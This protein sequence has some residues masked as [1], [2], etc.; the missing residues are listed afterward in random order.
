MRTKWLLIA[1]PLAILALLLQSSIWVPTYASQARTNPGRLVT[2]IR[3]TIGEVKHLNPVVSSDYEANQLMSENL[4]EGLVFADEN[5]GLSPKLAER[6]ETTE[7]AYV[8]VL[9]ERR[10]RDGSRATPESLAAR[11][12][13]AWKQ[14]QLGALSNSITSVQVV[15]SERRSATE[16]V[17]IKNA[18]GKD[19]PADVE[20]SID[21]PPRVQLELSRVEPQLFEKLAEILGDAYFEPG[22]FESRFTL[23]KPE[24]LDAVRSKLPELLQVGEH[25][26]IVTFHLRPGVHWHDGVPMTAEDVKFTYQATVDPRNASPLAGSFESIKSVDVVDELT[27]RITYK[28]LY[29]PAIMDWTSGIIPKHL[30]DDAALG[31]EMQRRPPAQRSREALTLRTTAFNRNP[32]GTGP[33]RFAEWLPGQY[34]RL[35]RNEQY[36]GK[37]AEYRDYYFRIIPDFLSMELEFGAG[38]VDMYYAQPHQAKRYRQ[39]PHYQ[40]LSGNDGAYSYIGYNM[41]RP[42]FQ[43]V[44]VRRALGMAIDVD[45]IIKYV[46]AGE[47]KRATGPY[48]SNTPYFDPTVAPLAYDPKGA[49]ELLAEAGW[50]KNAKGMLEKQGQPF[51]FTLVTNNGN[52]SRKAIM[53]IAQEAWRKLGIDIKVQAF[54]WT[55]FLEEFVEAGNFDA[56]VLAWGGGGIN[57]DAHTIWHSSQSHPHEK[58]MGAY[59]SARADELIMKIRTTYDS[60]AT[61]RLTHELHRVIAE[62]QPYTFLYEP[63][64]P[65]VFDKRIARVRRGPNG[66]ERFEKLTVP[67]SGDVFQFFQEWRKLPTVPEAMR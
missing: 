63:L 48:Y 35:T 18:K 5:L 11:I 41:R 36:W 7:L 25:N 15:A 24:L 12:E 31:R 38:A 16:T 29:S 54:E 20:L 44:R 2:F 51:S 42:L 50:H 32:I 47:G 59:Q 37:K 22:N 1:L 62:D 3:A 64:R 52:L 14:G 49:L 33:F 45:A 46:L 65:H 23:K 67:A 13:A 58:N 61:I 4:F 17:L 30:L 8:A 6:W 55:V 43:D 27:A 39:D 60:A 26:P 34:I 66:E 10:L 9:P 19:E 28:R 56:F 57:P 21:V 40:V 53:T